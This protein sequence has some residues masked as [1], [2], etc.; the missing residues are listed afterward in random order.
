MKELAI[1]AAVLAAF[2]F[3][4]GAVVAYVAARLGWIKGVELRARK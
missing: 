3:P 1:N 4:L 2:I